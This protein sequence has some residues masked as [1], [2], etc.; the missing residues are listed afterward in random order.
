MYITHKYD[1]Y[2][3]INNDKEL[4]FFFNKGEAKKKNLLLH[5][6]MTFAS[7]IST[8]DSNPIYDIVI[9]LMLVTKIYGIQAITSMKHSYDS[10]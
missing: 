1:D 2:V 6:T 7:F 8:F 9:Q 10:S 5:F 4:T 3:E